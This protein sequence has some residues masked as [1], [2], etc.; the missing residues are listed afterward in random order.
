[1]LVIGLVIVGAHNLLDVL[2]P[3]AFGPF[4][5]AWTFLH[6]GGPLHAGGAPIG[7]VAYPV[8]PWIGVMAL[9]YGL[10]DFFLEAPS[11]RDRKL[12]ALSVAM[13]GAFLVLRSFNL[14]GEPEAWRTQGDVIRSA[15]V[16]LDVTKYP[17]S[18]LYVLATLGL[19]FALVPLLG[20]LNGPAARSLY[21]FGAVP[22][23]FYVLHVYL[24][25]GL[26]IV[27]NAALGRDVEDMFNF[28]ANMVSA[29]ERYLHLG[30]PLAG[31]YLAWLVVLAMLFPLC[32]WWGAVKRNRHDWWLSYL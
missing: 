10:G 27:A 21:T 19:A 18:L 13:L 16:F 22:L 3:R 12:F 20:R 8:L 24:V 2:T 6:E 31:A 11:S 26:A 4:A 7:F 28:F 17:P 25:H 1:V 5:L 32:R 30:F 29:P 15:M 9:G 23:F 14:Y